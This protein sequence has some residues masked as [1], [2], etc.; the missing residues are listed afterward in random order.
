MAEHNRANRAF[1]EA[2][3][4]DQEARERDEQFKVERND[5]YCEAVQKKL[6]NKQHQKQCDYEEMLTEKRNID[7]VMRRIADED[8]RELQYKHDQKEIMRNEMMTFQK[9]REDMKEKQKERVA[10]ENRKIEEQ[11]Q[12]AS[13]RF[14]AMEFQH[15]HDQTE[16]MRNEMITFQKEREDLKE[17]QKERVA[18]E[19]QKIG[20]QR[21]VASDRI[22]AMEFQN[23]RDE[24]EMMR[25]EMITCQKAREDM[26]EKQTE[27]LKIENRKIGE[28]IQDASDRFSA[29]EFQ[30]KH[31][32]TELMRN[33]MITFQK[34]REDL[35]EEQKERVAIEN[36]KIEKQRQAASD[37]SSAIVAEREEQKQR[38]YEAYKE[39]TTKM[40]ADEATRRHREDEMNELQREECADRNRRD[41]LAEWT[42]SERACSDLKEGLLAQM[43]DKKLAAAEQRARDVGFRRS[44]ES[45]MADEDE[46]EEE[47][48]RKIKEIND[49][50]YSDLRQ[51]IKDNAVRRQKEKAAEDKRDRVEYELYNE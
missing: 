22:S 35:K 9:E 31:D 15:K 17:K 16:I 43:E 4:N 32:E 29:M 3:Y 8:Q 36:R 2:S 50:Y 19:N 23:K 27:R 51:Q 40:L 10:I 48:Q 25:N 37:R 20:E 39:V 49:Q 45:Q 44:M 13:D 18:I 47:K 30:N 42:R 38:N 12:V 14:S 33:E 11:R 5:Q 6:V 34:E 46:I 7:I 1:A 21:Q 41:D 28:Q 24:T 26:K